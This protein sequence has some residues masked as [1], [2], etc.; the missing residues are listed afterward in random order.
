MYIGAKLIFIEK[1]DFA[2]KFQQVNFANGVSLDLP[3]TITDCMLSLKGEEEA[4]SEV[5]DCG[6]A[7]CERF[8]GDVDGV[9]ISV[10]KECEVPHHCKEQPTKKE[11]SG[12]HEKDPS[13][14]QV[15]DGDENVLDELVRASHVSHDHVQVTFLVHDP[16][17]GG[18]PCKDVEQPGFFPERV[19]SGLGGVATNKAERFRQDIRAQKVRHEVAFA[20][21]HRI[22]L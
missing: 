11:G 10:L 2:A 4:R 20:S 15:D 17:S 19:E 9:K 1:R 6:S 16:I 14:G 18:L 12:E 13:P 22:G 5:L 3:D 21:H 7:W 8:V